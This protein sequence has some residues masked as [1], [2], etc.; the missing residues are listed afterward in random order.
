MESKDDKRQELLNWRSVGK[1]FADAEA[2]VASA[3]FDLAQAYENGVGVAVDIPESIRWLK[4]AAENLHP[5][6]FY[7]LGVAFQRGISLRQDSSVAVEYFAK[8]AHLGDILCQC[9]LADAYRDGRGIAKDEMAA[10]NWYTKASEQGNANAQYRLGKMYRYGTGVQRDIVTAIQFFSAAAEQGHAG[11]ATAL[12]KAKQLLQAKLSN[13]DPQSRES[14]AAQPQGSTPFIMVDSSVLLQDPDVIKRVIGNK[15]LPCITNTILSELDYNKKNTDSTVANNA[16]LLLRE[17][18]KVDPVSILDLPGGGRPVNGDRVEQFTY[19]G[20]ILLVF[21]RDHHRGDRD[22]DSKIIDVAKDYGMIVIT[23]DSGLKVRAQAL[24]VQA[25]VWTARDRGDS[26][27]K[28]SQGNN[29]P[30]RPLIIPF[31]ICQDP[32]I[33]KAVVL[34]ISGI[35][36]EGDFV[37]SGGHGRIRLLKALSAGGEGTIFET[38]WDD[39]VCKIYHKD[40][41]TSIQQKKIELMLSRKIIKEGICWPIDSVSNDDGQ[42]VGYLMPRAKGRPMQHTMFVKPVLEKSFPAWSRIDLVNLCIAFL[43]KIAYLHNLNI[44]VGDINPLNVLIT[45][46]SN[47]VWFVDTDSFQIEGFPCPVGTVN[48]TAPEIQG[49][50]YAEFMRTREH[51]L[52]AISTMLFMILH[53][54]KP[55]YA[56]QGG[57]DPAL[58]I[59]KQNF[60]YPYGKDVNNKAPEGPWQNIWAN[61]PGKIKEAFWNTFKNNQRIEVADWKKLLELYRAEILKEWHSNEI[62]PTTFKIVDPVEVVCGK[63][64]EKVV[65][66]E[67]RYLRMISERKPFY[68]GKCMANIRLQILARKSR[69]A[70]QSVNTGRSNSVK[71]PFYTQQ[72]KTPRKPHYQ[73]GTS[74]SKYI[75][76]E[77]FD[78]IFNLFR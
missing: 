2:G 23:A 13:V 76:S 53:P 25:Y 55:P 41:L 78:A 47:S 10:V 68:C 31:E 18:A 29:T 50:N 72:P 7:C 57:G 33:E 27:S 14:V 12:E 26:E 15:G 46:Q 28:K 44:I 62:F 77:F 19:M 35:P 40:R 60:A 1:L 6:A 71:S 63:C 24:G 51:E 21:A 17:L 22:N 64:S 38:D 52:F 43:D 65:A 49:I 36:A 58:N 20:N 45:D 37:F 42:F 54:G 67:K 61:L 30:S 34:K 16:R 11:A 56:Q 5:G 9:A 70:K 39:C 3:Q 66:S 74:S 69:D 75:V 32:F 8:G 73:Q 48:Y 4:I 59:K